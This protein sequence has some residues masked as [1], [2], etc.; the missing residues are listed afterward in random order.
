MVAK[1]DERNRTPRIS[2]TEFCRCSMLPLAAALF[3][4][5]LLCWAS[6]LARTAGWG[7]VAPAMH[8]H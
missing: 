6:C 7:K 5:A 3:A 8:C 1:A 4:A 2:S